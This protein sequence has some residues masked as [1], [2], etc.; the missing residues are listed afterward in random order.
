MLSTPGSIESSATP[1]AFEML[2]FLVID[3]DFEVVKVSLAVVA[4]RPL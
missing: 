2:G 1:F 4:P 3:E